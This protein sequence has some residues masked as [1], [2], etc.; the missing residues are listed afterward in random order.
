MICY[1]PIML[2]GSFVPC[3]K[4]LNCRMNERRRTTARLLL[5]SFEH[6][7]NSFVTL[8]YSPENLP[9]NGNVCARDVQLFLKRLRERVAPVRFRYFAVG[10][11]GGV[12][13]RPH[14][15]ALL[16]GWA[17]E[18]HKVIDCSCQLCAAWSLGLCHVGEVTPQSAQYV[19]G[20]VLKVAQVEGLTALS[21]NRQGRGLVKGRE[22]EFCLR[23]RRPGI[24]AGAVPRIVQALRMITHGSTISEG[25]LRDAPSSVRVTGSGTLPI[26]GYLQRKVREQLLGTHLS[27]VWEQTK[28]NRQKLRM[29]LSVEV[30][31]VGVLEI[32]KRERHGAFMSAL[33]RYRLK[34][35]KEVL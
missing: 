31:T 9:A 23:S 28:R 13:Q 30:G 20:Y 21:R 22:P 15:H 1:D 29:S 25:T 24:G 34:K 3:A 2:D 26:S 10:E 8:T 12:G 19:A 17:P 14:Y 18:N 27:P 11:Y 16:F 33:S 4:C 6:A 35:S 32:E 5:E 7:E